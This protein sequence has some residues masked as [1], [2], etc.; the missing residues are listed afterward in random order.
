MEHE[1]SWILAWQVAV[2]VAAGFLGILLPNW[3]SNRWRRAAAAKSTLVSNRL[4]EPSLAEAGE[5][6]TAAGPTA[7]PWPEN[8][9]IAPR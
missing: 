5:A 6:P 8:K 9:A 2:P 3:L 4:N 7:S 1:V